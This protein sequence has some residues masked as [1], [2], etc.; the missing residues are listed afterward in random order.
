MRYFMFLLCC[1]VGSVSQFA[2]FRLTEPTLQHLF[3]LQRGA[4]PHRLPPPLS[5]LWRTSRSGFVPHPRL[6]RLRPTLPAVLEERRWPLTA[7]SAKPDAAV[8]VGRVVPARAAATHAVRVV[9]PAP[10]PEVPARARRVPTPL[11][12][13][14]THVVQAI[15]IRR[16]TAHRTR[17]GIAARLVGRVVAARSAGIIA[18]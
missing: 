7:D 16:K 15:P 18:V 5:E 2:A 4:C 8:H 13:I 3:L 11:P 12:H 10:A 17:V 14:S 9:A 6:A 1:N